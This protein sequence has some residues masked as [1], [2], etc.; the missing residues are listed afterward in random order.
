MD[1]FIGGGQAASGGE[2]L[3]KMLQGLGF[4]LREVS[5]TGGGISTPVNV[6]SDATAETGQF[7]SVTCSSVDI[8]ITLPDPT[9]E[10][11]I[12]HSIWIHK[13]D[14]TAFKVLTSVKDLAFQNSTMHLISNGISWV[15]S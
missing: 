2:E 1:F 6:I 12:G 3:A 8:T 4:P 7:I 14:A 9:L 11:N 10:D 13:V 5:D 15:V